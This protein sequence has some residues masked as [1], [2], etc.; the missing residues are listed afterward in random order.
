MTDISALTGAANATTNTNA[1]TKGLSDTFDTFLKLL[2]AQLQNQDPLSPMDSS[3][4][5]EQLVQ[6]SQVEQQIASNTKLDTLAAQLKASSAGSALSYLGNTATF[7]SDAKALTDDGASWKYALGASSVDTKISIVDAKGNTVYTTTGERGAG[8]H[9]FAW[10]GK[11]NSGA[12]APDGI[13]HLKVAATDADGKTIETAIAV[14]EMITGVDFSGA[15][16]TVT[17][18]A[19]ARDFDTILRVEKPT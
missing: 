19:G 9:D 6:Y 4:F 5:T 12:D 10:D 3:K 15:S 2:T 14:Q 17:T 8:A 13:Y 1:A 11:T 7:N 16:P 18:A